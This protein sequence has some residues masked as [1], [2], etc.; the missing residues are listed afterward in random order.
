MAKLLA[1]IETIVTVIGDITSGLASGFGEGFMDVIQPVI[2]VFKELGGPGGPGGLKEVF[3]AVGKVLGW[4]V[5]VFAVG[6]GAIAFLVYG[7]VEAV[8]NAARW[9]GDHW[10]TVKAVFVTVAGVILAPF[11]AI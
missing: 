2:D 11:I 4:L 10:E 7:L 6:V 9:I 5:A 8:R 3:K 1:T